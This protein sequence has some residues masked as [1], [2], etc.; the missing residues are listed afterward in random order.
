MRKKFLVSL[1]A[2]T[3]LS[4][5]ACGEQTEIPQDIEESVYNSET[6]T[7][8]EVVSEETIQQSKPK[9]ITVSC[10]NL[11][12]TISGDYFTVF[13]ELTSIDFSQS[14]DLFITDTSTALMTVKMNFSTF[15]SNNTQTYIIF[16]DAV[17][18]I[19]S[20][21]TDS[22]SFIS[23]DADFCK[24]LVEKILPAISEKQIFAYSDISDVSD[25]FV[26]QSEYLSRYREILESGVYNEY[27]TELGTDSGDKIHD[28]SIINDYVYYREESGSGF[29]EN[30]TGYYDIIAKGNIG[31]ERYSDSAIWY[32]TEYTGTYSPYIKNITDNSTYSESY[33]LTAYGQKCLCEKYISQDG[34]SYLLY[35]DE[36]GNISGFSEFDGKKIRFFINYSLYESGGLLDVQKM[37]EIFSNAEQNVYIETPSPSEENYNYSF[38]HNANNIFDFDAERIRGENIENPHIVENMRNYFDTADEFT[39]Y[40]TAQRDDLRMSDYATKS[41]DS[42]YTKSELQN[43][44]EKNIITENIE[45]DGKFYS[46]CQYEGEN[47]P[48]T[49]YDADS[50]DIY[51]YYIIQ[52]NDRPEFNDVDQF[53]EAYKVTIN[54][55]EYICE[56]WHAGVT[57]F[58]VYCKDGRVVAIDTV[59]YDEHEQ[60][61]IEY[62]YDYPETQYITLPENYNIPSE[63]G[64]Q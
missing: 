21:N 61:V 7:S 56:V 43:G 5:S 53:V 22:I 50:A 42:Y 33:T 39:I 34:K 60:T 31:Y 2:L 46:R 55:E 6:E 23:A 30:S 58:N 26:E 52:N 25:N 15:L 28:F 63:E 64:N 14:S 27:F 44:N 51:I 48:F 17:G 1:L 4:F 32:Q 3:V 49:L 8:T 11:S 20:K 10:G 54:N 37:T 45:I 35:F 13:E 29:S 24:S 41:G 18:Y 38:E 62:M 12:S 19:P 9:D 47:E 59:F 57:D 36:Y 16:P 40:I